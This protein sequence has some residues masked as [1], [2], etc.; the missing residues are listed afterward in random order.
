MNYQELSKVL[1]ARIDELPVFFAFSDSQF[2]EGCKRLGVLEPKS[3]LTSIG[4]GGF[5]KKSDRHLMTEAFRLNREERDAWISDP[6]NLKQAFEYELGNY[7]YCYSEDD[8]QIFEA[9][10][11]DIKES[12]PEQRT[13][14]V[15][16]RNNYLNS[17]EW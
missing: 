3:E 17:V 6:E 14:F 13:I 9:V 4:A 12:T 8:E 5:M 1:Q 2:D 10:G 11:L 7:E 15:A 16:A